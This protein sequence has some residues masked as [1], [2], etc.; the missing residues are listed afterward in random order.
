MSSLTSVRVSRSF[1]LGVI[2]GD[3]QEM[4]VAWNLIPTP[5]TLVCLEEMN[6]SS[7]MDTALYVYIV[8]KEMR[9]ILTVGGNATEG[10][11]CAFTFRRLE[12]LSEAE[13][14]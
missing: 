11:V 10:A 6:T 14:S 8:V 1:L 12:L 7:D 5:G 13:V 3:I 4:I 9:W 2:S